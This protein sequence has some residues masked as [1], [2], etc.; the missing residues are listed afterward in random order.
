MLGRILFPLEMFSLY[1]GCFYSDKRDFFSIGRTRYRIMLRFNL[2]E[3]SMKP[4]NQTLHLVT[5]PAA[6]LPLDAR[7]CD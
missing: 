6:E 2:R 5:H 7:Q 3:A 4:T 1:E